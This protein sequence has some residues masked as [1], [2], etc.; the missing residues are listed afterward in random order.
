MEWYSRETVGN[1]WILEAPKEIISIPTKQ[2]FSKR[3]WRFLTSWA[4]LRGNENPL[5]IGV[6]QKCITIQLKTNRFLPQTLELWLPA[7]ALKQ[8]VI[9]LSHISSFCLVVSLPLL[10]AWNVELC[11][12]SQ[13]RK[14]GC[15]M[16]MNI[17]VHVWHTSHIHMP[18]IMITWAWVCLESEIVSS[19]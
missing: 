11:M 9:T 17:Y 10:F 16:P 1:N 2:Q 5:S 14:S 4:K 12:G 8:S 3:R 18:G 13:E 7:A 19:P 6:G 15:C